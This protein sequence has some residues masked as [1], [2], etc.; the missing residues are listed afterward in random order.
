MTYLEMYNQCNRKI[1]IL[2]LNIADMISLVL[3]KKI[4]GN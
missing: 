4:F 3:I 1:P 2:D